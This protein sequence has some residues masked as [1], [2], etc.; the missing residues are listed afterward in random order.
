MARVLVIDDRP[1]DREFLQMLLGFVG[2]TV[3]AAGDGEEG[4]RIA[5][6]QPPD[7]AIVDIVMPTMDG[8]EFVNRLRANPQ[9]AKTKIIFYSAS[10][11]RTEAEKLAIAGGVQRVLQKPAEPEAILKS[12][13]E[14][15]GVVRPAQPMPK[16]DV[17]DHQALLTVTLHK[18]ERE[19]ESISQR[20]AV[21]VDLAR[22]FATVTDPD[23]LLERLGSAARSVVGARFAVV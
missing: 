9:L 15:L 12:V 16:L 20:L 10:Y 17:P 4:L 3:V 1:T 7:L 11:L 21:L 13:N 6:E 18:T 14:V 5:H 19:L 2:H 8:L 22:E 23:R